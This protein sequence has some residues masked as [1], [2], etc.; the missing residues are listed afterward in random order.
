MPVF[1]DNDGVAVRI[2]LE[3]MLGVLRAA[4]EETRLRIL[5]LLSLSELTVSDLTEILGQ[6]QPRVSR[7]LKLLSE[8]GLVVRGREGSYSFYRLSDERALRAPV[9]EL[10]S[11]LDAAD[12]VLKRDAARLDA[13]RKGRAETAARYFSAHAEKWNELRTL[14]VEEAAVESAI[15]QTLG[16]GRFPVAVDLG[17]GTGRILE[18]IAPQ[19]GTGIG[20]DT[21]PDMLRI[22]RSALDAKGYGHCRVQ[23]GDIF[24]LTLPDGTADLVVIHQVLHYLHDAG[25]AIAEAAR[26]LKPGGCL[27][28][29]DFAPHG[30]E[31]LRAGHAHV[32]LGIDPA[33]MNGW[34]D[35]A[36]LDLVR[37][38][39]L[40]AQ[41]L[42]EDLPEKLIVSLWLARDR[43]ASS[44]GEAAA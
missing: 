15:R 33:E 26:I 32:R 16:G 39:Q 2:A 6:S 10:L 40:G 18:L 7:H 38:D 22:A 17:T 35:D 21:S 27:L 24:N 19:V 1:N 42:S 12:L 28:I 43:R 23:Q 37:T 11:H 34:L 9:K 14:H 30:F 4:A 13:V 44:E 3:P 25:A 41:G 31:F 20:V 5:R 36:G 29:V 8:A